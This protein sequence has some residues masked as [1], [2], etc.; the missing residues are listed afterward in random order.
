[1]ATCS[2]NNIIIHHKMGMFDLYSQIEIERDIERE[3]ERGGD[4]REERQK[5][6]DKGRKIESLREKGRD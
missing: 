1:M 2:V 4:E 3:R 6:L 5:E